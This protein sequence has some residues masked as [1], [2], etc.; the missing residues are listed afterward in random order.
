MLSENDILKAKILIVDDEESSVKLVEDIFRKAGYNNITTTRDSR[1]AIDLYKELDPDLLVLDLVMPHMDGFQIMNQLKEINPD[2]YLPIV[3]LTNESDQDVRFKALESGAKDFLN[4]PYDRVEVL[5]RFRN[6]IE[7][8]MLQNQVQNQNRLLEEKVNLRT[9]EL[10][11]TQQDV[12]H[13]LA[14]AIEYRDSET[15]LHII[16][17][18]HYT[19]FLAKKAGLNK[20]DC[21]LILTASPLHDIGKIGIPDSIL[22]K[23]GRLSDEEWEIMKTHTTIG[24]EL[25]SGSNSKFMRMAREI[26]ISHHEKWDGTGYPYGLKGEEIPLVGR[27][28]G[29]TDVFDALMTIRPYK[30]AWPVDKTMDEIKQGRGNH[31]DPHLVDCFIEI[32]P[33]IRKVRDKYIDPIMK[34]DE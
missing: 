13:R 11:E 32:L 22:Q 18:S 1:K 10:N 4:K 12:I 26:A 3:I 20:D 30:V 5:I 16:R 17:M 7:V 25:L 33:D 14:R 23:P 9:R 34:T 31:F 21:E 2:S 24:A 8:R 6:L 27:I 29:I 15:G 19:A 28:C